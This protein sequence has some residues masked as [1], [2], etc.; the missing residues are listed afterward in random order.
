MTK[1]LVEHEAPCLFG[2]FLL[3]RLAQV[4]IS[5]KEKQQQEKQH[6][7]SDLFVVHLSHLHPTTKV[8]KQSKSSSLSFHSHTLK[9]KKEGRKPK[10]VGRKNKLTTRPKR[11]SSKQGTKIQQSSR[12]EISSKAKETSNQSINLTQ[13]S[14]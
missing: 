2:I 9:T 11:E 12:R 6:H 7:S 13:W 3:F 1:V 5:Y 8:W 14:S 4:T 10:E